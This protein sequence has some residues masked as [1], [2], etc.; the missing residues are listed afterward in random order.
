MIK[1]T[2]NEYRF[3]DV[4]LADQYANWSFGACCALYDYLNELSD[5]IGKDIELD[6]V[7]LRCEWTEYESAWDAM[8]QYQPDDMPTVDDEVDEDGRGLDLVELS[9]LQEKAAREWLEERTVVL[10]VENVDTGAN[11]YRTI[12]SILVMRF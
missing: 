5:D 4:L 1:E 7:A 8:T 10:D 3:R 6:P 2:V 11:E 12:K 9:E